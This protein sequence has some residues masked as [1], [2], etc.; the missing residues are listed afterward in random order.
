MCSREAI[1]GRMYIQ[2]DSQR[3]VLP[4]G[5]STLI[6]LLWWET[7]LSKF[8]KSL[9][10][11][12]QIWLNQED[13]MLG[14]FTLSEKAIIMLPLLS[15]RYEC[16]RMKWLIFWSFQEPQAVLFFL[17]R[18]LWERTL[19]ALTNPD[20][21]LASSDW[22][23][24]SFYIMLMWNPGVKIP[25]GSENFLWSLLCNWPS[26]SSWP[27]WHWWQFPPSWFL[28]VSKDSYLKIRFGGIVWRIRTLC[29]C[30]FGG[31]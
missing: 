8:P 4:S 15:A 3:V 17:L 31:A 6:N 22:C 9:K 2:P 28:A 25:P 23:S 12:L 14:F 11:A 10:G 30:G 1:A 21:G 16:I 7:R 27:S 29:G 5:C 19:L 26:W 24:L 20:S 18:F 13:W